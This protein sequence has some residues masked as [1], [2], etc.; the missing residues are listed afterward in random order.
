MINYNI[1]LFFILFFILFGCNIF[2]GET[3]NEV[4]LNGYHTLQKEE[5]FELAAIGTYKGFGGVI[6]INYSINYPRDIN[7]EEAAEVGHRLM[8][9]LYREMK[10][11][12]NWE[13]LFGSKLTLDSLR[14]HIHFPSSKVNWKPNEI[15]SIDPTLADYVGVWEGKVSVSSRDP[16]TGYPNRLICEPL[17]LSQEKTLD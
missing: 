11:E 17:R 3:V 7:P 4:V 13:A 16:E 6:G 5:E 9:V 1:K 8:G 15:N 12:P 2:S 10:K 14:I